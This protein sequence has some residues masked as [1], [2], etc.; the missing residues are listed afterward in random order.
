MEQDSLDGEFAP[1]DFQTLRERVTVMK[2]NYHQLLLDKDYLLEVC[3]MYHGALKWKETEV[4]RLTHELVNTQGFL[5]GTQTTLQESESELEELLEEASHGSTTSISA[6][7]QIYT[8]ATLLEDVGSLIKECQLMEEHEGY[9]GSL[10][11]MERCDPETLEDVHV[12]QGPPFMRG[13]ETVGHTCTH[14]DSRARG[15]YEDTSIC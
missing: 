10:M 1:E 6:K 11:I 7:S 9:P 5:K 3:E 15:S 13:S 12:S 14:G 2:T 8:S 4:D